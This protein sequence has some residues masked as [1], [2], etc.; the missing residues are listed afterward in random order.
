MSRVIGEDPVATATQ[1]RDDSDL[2]QATARLSFVGP[3][4]APGV[5]ATADP[6]PWSAFTSEVRLEVV[7]SVIMEPAPPRF[8]RLGSC[9]APLPPDRPEYKYCCIQHRSLDLRVFEQ[10]Q[11][12]T[13]SAVRLTQEARAMSRAASAASAASGA[14]A[15]G[16]LGWP[17]R[18]LIAVSSSADE[19]SGVATGAS[20]P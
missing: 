17:I 1:E 13:T 20:R 7:R 5:S 16:L 6:G 12:S 10:T 4:P 19:A 3:R 8:C 15:S 2:A 14:M 11:R 9:R 18:V